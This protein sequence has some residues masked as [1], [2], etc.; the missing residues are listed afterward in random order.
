MK[1]DIISDI[2]I[3][4]FVDPNRYRSMS[5]EEYFEEYFKN[6]SSEN[7]IIAGDLSHSNRLSV[8]ALILLRD[9]YYKRVFFVLGNHDYYLYNDEDKIKFSDSFKKVQE[10]KEMVSVMSDVYL[11][12]GDVVEV[13]G[14]KIGGATAWYDGSYSIKYLKQSKDDILKDWKKRMSDAKYIKGI[15][16][17]FDMFDMQM[18]KV[19]AI[20]KNSNIIITHVNPMS[21]KFALHSYQEDRTLSGFYTFDGSEYLNTT[22]AKYWIFGHMHKAHSYEFSGVK[23]MSNPLG[24]P[25]QAKRYSVKSIEVIKR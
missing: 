19:E 9:K 22:N 12:D 23:V 2:H 18:K 14:V 6:A 13:K 1:F 4:M 10:L 8:E 15:N 17:L 3:D 21:E 25:A 16:N 7:L 20:Y 11:L 24:Y 5:L